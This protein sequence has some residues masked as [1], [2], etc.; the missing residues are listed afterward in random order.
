MIDVK[1]LI[2]VLKKN[3]FK[4]TNIEGMNF[5]PLTQEWYLSKNF[6]PVNYFCTAEFI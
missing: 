6:Y 2:K 5:N 1:D 3:N 4:I